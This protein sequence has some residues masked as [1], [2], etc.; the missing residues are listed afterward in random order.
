CKTG[1]RRECVNAGAQE[2]NRFSGC[3]QHTPKMSQGPTLFSCGIFG[4]APIA[5]MEGSPPTT[6]VPL[7]SPQQQLC[8]V[9]IAERIFYLFPSLLM[10]LLIFRVINL[11]GLRLCLSGGSQLFA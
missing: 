1:I 2:V 4:W 5:G 11:W 3:L 6:P 8:P 7:S 10:H 9:A